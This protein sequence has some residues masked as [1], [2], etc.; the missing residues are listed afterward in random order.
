MYILNPRLDFIHIEQ[1]WGDPQ[2]DKEWGKL[3]GV[4]LKDS[5]HKKGIFARKD[6]KIGNVFYLLVCNQDFLYAKPEFIDDESRRTAITVDSFSEEKIN[7]FIRQKI[8]GIGKVNV[9]Q[10]DVAMRQTFDMSDWDSDT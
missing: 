7:N 8:E 1:E 5:Y 6:E 4:Y 10:F 2:R 9:E 3:I